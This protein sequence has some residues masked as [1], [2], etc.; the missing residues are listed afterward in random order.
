MPAENLVDGLLNTI[1]LLH[2]TLSKGY[3][4]RTRVFLSSLG[5]L[6]EGSIVSTLK[7][8]DAVVQEA[9]KQAERVKEQEAKSSKPWKMAGMGLGAVAG[10]VL[11]G[12]TG[13]LG[14]CLSHGYVVGFDPLSSGSYRWRKCIYPVGYLWTRWDGCWSI[15]H[16]LS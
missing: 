10:G 15:G 13:G 3:S 5:T 2:I 9:Q 16:R 7:D 12:I 1:L 14:S 11:I 8:P 4:A 6:N